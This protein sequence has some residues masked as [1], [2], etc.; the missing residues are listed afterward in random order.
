MQHT[1]LMKLLQGDRHRV[2]WFTIPL[3]PVPRSYY[4]YCCCCCRIRTRICFLLQLLLLLLLLLLLQ[5]QLLE[6]L[7]L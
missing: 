2:A 4:C 7:L 6:W 5:P 1:T 3:L